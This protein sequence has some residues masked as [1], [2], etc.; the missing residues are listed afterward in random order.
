MIPRSVATLL[1]ADGYNATILTSMSVLPTRIAK[2]RRYRYVVFIQS[3]DEIEQREEE[4][5][6]YVDEVPVE[7]E[8][9]DGM[10]V[11]LEVAAL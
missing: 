9:L 7:T 3:L 10:I 5:P 11:S 6:D 4:D 2:T 1:D 8:V